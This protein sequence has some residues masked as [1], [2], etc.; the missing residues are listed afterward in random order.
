[1]LIT[2]A[3]AARLIHR[4]P[5]NASAVLQ[6][7][8]VKPVAADAAVVEGGYRWDEDEVKAL[9]ERTPEL[10]R[11]YTPGPG[12]QVRLGGKK[13]KPKNPGEWADIVASARARTEAH[14]ET[15]WQERQRERER[16]R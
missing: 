15:A 14:F 12:I 1:M 16:A 8:G 3:A 2:T 11:P 9:V 13:N 4:S 10:Q 7:H 5:T 6:R